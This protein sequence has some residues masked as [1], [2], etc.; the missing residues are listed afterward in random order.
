MPS[1]KLEIYNYEHKISGYTYSKQTKNSLQF[2]QETLL[3]ENHAQTTQG[4]DQLAYIRTS[5]WILDTGRSFRHHL[6]VGEGA[7][8]VRCQG[9]VHHWVKTQ[10]SR[11]TGDVAKCRD[12]FGYSCPHAGVEML[13]KCIKDVDHS[14]NVVDTNTH[15]NNECKTC[16][17]QHV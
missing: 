8:W 6:L 5:A 16:L 11:I 10:V 14:V 13:F 12:G 2:T 9:L 17:K 7:V 3:S 1:F 4:K 15:L